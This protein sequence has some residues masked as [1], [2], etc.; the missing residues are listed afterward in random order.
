MKAF[1]LACIATVM[2]AS[3]FWPLQPNPLQ[4][5]P[6][7]IV[8]KKTNELAFIHDGAIQYV[9]PVA[10][11][12]RPAST[13]EGLFTIVVKAENPYYR[14]QNIP[15]GSPANPLGTRWIGFDAL[16]TDGRTYGIHGTN[17][18]ETIGRHLS[19]GC[20]RMLNR[21][22]EQ[23]YEQIPLGTKILITSSE[24]NFQQIAKRFH[25]IESLQKGNAGEQ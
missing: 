16:Q 15:G 25:V 17:R 5:D 21:D 23:L 14:K 18:P 8:N 3:P 11:G 1:L 9:K 6:F 7:I 4:G 24:E 2:I 22:V 19:S 12:K 13:P 10:T 20:I